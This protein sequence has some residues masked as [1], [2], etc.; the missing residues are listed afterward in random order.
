[1]RRIR[2]YNQYITL[3]THQGVMMVLQSL[4]MLGGSLAL[5][6]G[7]LWWVLHD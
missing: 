6:L 3:F 4:V 7:A 2:I 5:L 1:M